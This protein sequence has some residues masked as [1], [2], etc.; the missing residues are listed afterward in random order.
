MRKKYEMVMCSL[1]GGGFE[2]FWV[3]F[4]GGECRWGVVVDG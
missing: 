1:F 2:G 3:R 4:Y